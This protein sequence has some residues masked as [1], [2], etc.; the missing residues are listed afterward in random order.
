MG[1]ARLLLVDETIGS[2]RLT[3]NKPDT[4]AGLA[5]YSDFRKA[6]EVLAH[7][8]HKDRILAH[9]V[10]YP[11]ALHDFNRV[12]YLLAEYALWRILNH[13]RLPKLP[14]LGGGGGG[15]G[16]QPGIII[17]SAI[18]AVECDGRQRPLPSFVADDVLLRAI[19]IVNMQAEQ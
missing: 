18:D 16:F 14:S 11:I 3:R 6:S 5:L 4:L 19:L 10:L 2:R 1:T 17:L 12:C 15:G 9:R 13:H 7:V 8:E